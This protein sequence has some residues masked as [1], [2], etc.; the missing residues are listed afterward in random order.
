MK[1]L[2]VIILMLYIG[3]VYAC[4]E[5]LT[6]AY[7]L[8]ISSEIRKEIESI[9]SDFFK[10]V[11]SGTVLKHKNKKYS[12]LQKVGEGIEGTVFIAEDSKGKRFYLKVFDKQEG[13]FFRDNVSLFELAQ[14]KYKDIPLWMPQLD[15]QTKTMLWSYRNTVSLELYMDVSQKY[16]IWSS[17]DEAS[18]LMIESLNEKFGELLFIT[19]QN[20][21][22]DLD[23]GEVLISDPEGHDSEFEY[24]IIQ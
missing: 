17:T 19:P 18:Q 7:S 9:K 10:A 2:G 1:F 12:L 5:Q 8:N 21:L 3:E 4:I 11:K 22:V 15:E 24:K 16:T 20:V 23:T 6:N 14:K 13:E